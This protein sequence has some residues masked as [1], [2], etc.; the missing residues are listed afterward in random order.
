[1]ECKIKLYEATDKEATI[2]FLKSRKRGIKQYHYNPDIWN[3]QFI[4]NPNSPFSK[5]QVWL[6]KYGCAIIGQLGTIP[7]QLKISN[8]YYLAAWAVDFIVNIDY[9]NRGVGPLLI[10]ELDKAVDISLS[11]GPN[12][13]GYALC[14][15]MGWVEIGTV[16]LFVRYLSRKRIL[17][18]AIKSFLNNE[19]KLFIRLSRLFISNIFAINVRGTKDVFNPR[20]T[21]EQIS[22]FG[23]D[24]DDFWENASRSFPVIVRRDAKYLNWKFIENPIYSY[25]IYV[26]KEKEHLMG[27]IVLRNDK[28]SWRISDFLAIDDATNP[29]LQATVSHL[30]KQKAEKIICYLSNMN[31]VNRLKGFGF[32]EAKSNERLLFNVNKD[33]IDKGT[34]CKFS[35]WFISGS[36]GD[37]ER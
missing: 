36:D 26:A 16:P 12:K 23:K 7:V 4:K 29:L 31:Y 1:M 34:L 3:W 19:F 13:D 10:K 8:A 27:Y 24:F 17:K 20:F 2:Q 9:Q 5:V 18:D 14:K 30:K 6:F 33:K 32:V 21:I 22:A 28:R 11:L 25:T 35:N 37:R 15:K